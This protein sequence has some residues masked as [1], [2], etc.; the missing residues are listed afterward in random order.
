MKFVSAW[1]RTAAENVTLKVAACLLTI[2][3]VSQAIVI[4]KLSSREALVVERACLSRAGKMGSP[5]H[6][7]DEIEAFLSE[8]LPVRLSTEGL[9]GDFYLSVTQAET[10]KREVESL[11]AKQITQKFIFSKAAV[12][13]KE[14]IAEG[15][16]IL[17]VGAAKSVLPLKVR[18]SVAATMRS[19]GNPYGLVLTDVSQIE[20]EKN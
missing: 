14:I 2:V 6:T 20:K 1:V 17:S 16:R 19:E 8:A 5:K 4:L 13:E 3:A 11:K 15:D 9:S 7:S 18:V 12:T 10:K